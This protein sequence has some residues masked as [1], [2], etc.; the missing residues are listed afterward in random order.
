MG[1]SLW[2]YFLKGHDF[3]MLLICFAPH[4]FFLDQPLLFPPFFPVSSNLFKQTLQTCRGMQLHSVS[5][6]SS[7]VSE[8]PS[9]HKIMILCLS[10]Y[11]IF[12]ICNKFHKNNFIFI[13]GCSHLSLVVCQVTVMDT[14]LVKAS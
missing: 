1:A 5:F 7:A 2:I 4:P 3:Q 14:T 11:V 12:G 9:L 6:C 10:S 8:T 13:T